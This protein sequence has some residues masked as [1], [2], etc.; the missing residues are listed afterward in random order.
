MNILHYVCVIITILFFIIWNIIS[1]INVIKV[2]VW[3]RKMHKNIYFDLFGKDK[4]ISNS[5]EYCLILDL[6]IVVFLI[7]IVIIKAFKG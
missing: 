7:F 4:N 6:G 3:N 5:T 2:N 1:I